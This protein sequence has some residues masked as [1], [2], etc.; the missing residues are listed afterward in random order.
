[1][2]SL[3]AKVQDQP[4]KSA[5]NSTA[6]GEPVIEVFINETNKDLARYAT[7]REP[8]SGT[9]SSSSQSREAKPNAPKPRA[10]SA[11]RARPNSGNS[12]K[13][14]SISGKRGEVPKYLQN[15][16]AHLSAEKEMLRKHVEDRAAEKKCPPGTM[17]MPEE[18]KKEAIRALESRQ[19]ECEDALNRLPMRFDTVSIQKRRQELENEIQDIQASIKKFSRKEVF[20]PKY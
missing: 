12:D 4:T 2:Q 17:L 8:T 1:M 9:S 10:N 20:V 15:R 14:P 3:G 18:D 16:K 19:K 11:P 7:Y 5:N 6:P 13:A